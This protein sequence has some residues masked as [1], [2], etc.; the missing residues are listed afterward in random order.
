FRHPDKVSVARVSPR[1]DDV[2]ITRCSGVADHPAASPGPPPRSARRRAARP[3]RDLGR[4]RRAERLGG[5][6]S[7]A[8]AGRPRRAPAGTSGRT[9]VSGTATA[10]DVTGEVAVVVLRREPN[11]SDTSANA[12]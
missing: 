6:T 9:H 10:R 7:G 1:G 5:P 4:G 8:A 12:Y 3:V 2:N 11:L